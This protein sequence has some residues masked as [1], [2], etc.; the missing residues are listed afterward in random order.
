MH[1]VKATR[2]KHT[3]LNKIIQLRNDIDYLQLSILMG[4]IC[5]SSGYFCSFIGHDRTADILQNNQIPAY[6][7]STMPERM[8]MS[9]RLTSKLF[10]S[11]L[12][13]SEL[14]YNWRNK[15]G[16]WAREVLTKF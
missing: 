12:S 6:Q 8:R 14:S 11:R 9:M 4:H 15:Y 1:W 5:L 16:L 13:L 2:T 3:Q 10:L 7:R